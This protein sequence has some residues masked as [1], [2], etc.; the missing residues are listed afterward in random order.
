[1]AS[2]GTSPDADYR[3]LDTS[4]DLRRATCALRTPGGK[5]ELTS[6]LP[7]LY[8]AR[9]VAAALAAGDL[10]DVPRDHI[11]RAIASYPG[12]PGRFEHVD[13][14]QDCDVIVDFAHTPDS[15]EQFLRAVR[16]GMRADRRLTTVLGLGSRG[17]DVGYESMGRAARAL[18]DRLI[19]TTS[20]YQGQ[21]RMVT[22]QS[23]LRGARLVGGAK[24]EIVLDRRAAFERA[25][26]GASADDVIVIP[27]RGAFTEMRPGGGG[28]RIPFDDRVVAA[29]VLRVAAVRA[30]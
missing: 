10:L 30:G 16:A 5:L 20:G 19:L 11:V 17:D 25:L 23:F 4:W 27:G 22:L 13:V 29:E 7:G 8:N 14:G 12:V 18:S 1:V 24:V 3:V 6:R 15:V 9:N 26:A 21:P 28:L 2:V